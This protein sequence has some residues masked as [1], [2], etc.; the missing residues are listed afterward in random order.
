[1]SQ[2]QTG[3]FPRYRLLSS[4]APDDWPEEGLGAFVA[5]LRCSG[6]RYAVIF[7]KAIRVRCIAQKCQVPRGRVLFHY[8]SRET[9]ELI[10]SREGPYKRDR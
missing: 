3:A 7:E 1:M 4:S 10:E 5:V 8:F 2:S 9:G 6:E